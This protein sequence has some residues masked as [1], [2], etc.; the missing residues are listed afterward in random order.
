[1]AGTETFLNAAA[2]LPGAD[3]P[4]DDPGQPVKSSRDGR[5]TRSLL[6]LATILDGAPRSRAAKFDSVML[7]ILRDQAVRYDTIGLDG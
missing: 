3:F 5:Q 7:Q 1:M 6:A 2:V 4:G